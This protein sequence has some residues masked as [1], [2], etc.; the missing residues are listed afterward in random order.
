MQTMT[1]KVMEANLT[2][3]KQF[4][5]DQREKYPADLTRSVL[6]GSYAKGVAGPAEMR[7]FLRDSHCVD[8]P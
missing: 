3:V 6:F 1:T 5:R 2:V 8:L 4:A 7:R